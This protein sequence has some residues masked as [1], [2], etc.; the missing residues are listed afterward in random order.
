MGLDAIV[1][2]GGLIIPG[3]FDFVKKKFIKGENDTPER[4]IGTLA[5]TKPDVLADYTRAL[6]DYLKAQVDFFNRDVIG[7]ASGWV[8]D[9]R[10]A[11]RP[12]GV[13][14][15]FVILG[16][17][18]IAMFTGNYDRLAAIPNGETTLTGIRLTC[19]AVMT[20]WF[21]SRFAITGAK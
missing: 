5:T 12:F 11:I 19:E 14:L 7:Q 9:L 8:V 18:V 2:L 16:G 21:G 20:S 3:L 17:M 6:G 13:I 15:S 1:A 4:T 10:A